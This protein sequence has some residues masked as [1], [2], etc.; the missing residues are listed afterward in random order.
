[1]SKIISTVED[2]LN[3]I[4]QNSAITHSALYDTNLFEI[5]QVGLQRLMQANITAVAQLRNT[6][7]A[8][9]LV[10]ELVDDL[11]A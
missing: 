5:A 1:M 4:E 3:E 2:A 10:M 7:A 9:I 8:T 6:L 11:A